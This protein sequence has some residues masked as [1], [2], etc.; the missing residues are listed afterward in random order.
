MHPQPL[1][2]GTTSNR[3]AEHQS[4]LH[5]SPST[6]EKE[7]TTVPLQLEDEKTQESPETQTRNEPC[8]MPRTS[9][10]ADYGKSA[11]TSEEESNSLPTGARPVTRTVDHPMLAP[12]GRVKFSDPNR[13][14]TTFGSGNQIEVDKPL[15]YIDSDQTA[16]A[17]T[18]GFNELRINV[19]HVWALEHCVAT[20]IL[21]ATE[22][23]F[24]TPD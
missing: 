3:I 12:Q 22:Y 8:S 19:G 24:T 2:N 11:P 1:L 15:W 16:T 10:Q 18:H 21:P 7:L 23:T 14:V 13:V 17:D 20:G 5:T 6:F 4:T 9:R